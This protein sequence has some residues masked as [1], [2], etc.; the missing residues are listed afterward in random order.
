M[1]C[2]SL[3]FLFISRAGSAP[4]EHGVQRPENHFRVRERRLDW[5]ETA[6]QHAGPVIRY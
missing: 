4:V 6:R 1:N 3:F 2:P 5:E